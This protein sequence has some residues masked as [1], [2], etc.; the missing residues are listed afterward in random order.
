MTGLPKVFLPSSATHRMFLNLPSSTDQSVGR[1]FSNGLTMFRVGLPP[2]I[3]QER[4]EATGNGFV[5]PANARLVMLKKRQIH[6]K[7][8][9]ASMRMVPPGM[10]QGV[11]CW[12]QGNKSR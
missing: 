11:I 12:R 9:A 10:V 2:N 4:W 1:F 6:A 3:G 7:R 5:S 8:V